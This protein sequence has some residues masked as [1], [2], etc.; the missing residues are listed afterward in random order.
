MAYALRRETPLSVAE[1]VQALETAKGR[2]DAALTAAVRRADEIAPTVIALVEKAAD[3]VYLI[4]KQADLLFWGIHVLAAGR[5]TGLYRPLLRLIR[6]R[7]ER[8]LDRLL[9][10][11]TTETLSRLIISVFDG[12]S[13]PLL[14]ACEIGRASC[15]D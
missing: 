14:E 4:P 13:R 3:G 10:H 2:P 1:I 6:E 9:G 12:D 15:R 8:D 7:D 11:V 5:C